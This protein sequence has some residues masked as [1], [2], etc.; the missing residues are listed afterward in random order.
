MDT[1]GFNVGVFL[2]RVSSL[3]PLKCQTMDPQHLKWMH[4]LMMKFVVTLQTLIS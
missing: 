2:R 3:M 4:L 1:Q